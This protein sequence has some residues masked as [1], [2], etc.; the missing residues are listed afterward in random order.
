MY[1][2]LTLIKSI[3]EI[4]TFFLENLEDNFFTENE[5]KLVEQKNKIKS[6]GARYLIKK[7]ILEYLAIENK[8]KDIE[9]VNQS[10]GKPIVKFTGSVKEK[11]KESGITN[12][13]ISI[14]HS[15]NFISSIVILEQDV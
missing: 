2:E 1:K 9:I 10:T 15:R 8:Y 14:S 4:K 6:L 5:L 11:I 3:E 12:V 13:Q 7:S